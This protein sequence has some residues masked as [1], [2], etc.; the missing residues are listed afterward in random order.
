MVADRL[1]DRVDESDSP[2][3]EFTITR[4]FL[5]VSQLHVAIQTP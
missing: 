1:E 2:S 3:Y 5:N 4:N